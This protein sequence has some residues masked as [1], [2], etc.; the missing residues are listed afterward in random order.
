MS[1][2]QNF[3]GRSTFL[4]DPGQASA[5]QTGHR[6]H[7]TRMIEEHSQLVDLGRVRPDLLPSRRDV[8]AVLTATRVGTEGRGEER[9]RPPHAVIPHLAEGVRQERMPV[10]ISKVDRKVRTVGRELLLQGG[11][12]RSVL[13]IDRANAT[14]VLVMLGHFQHPFARHRPPAEHIF[15]ER[16]DI[17]RPLGTAKGHH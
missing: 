10:A 2:K 9:D 16:H 8:L 4:G 6:L 14:E 12:Q 15:E 5:Q 13:H 17:V 3:G 7:V 11:N 1:G